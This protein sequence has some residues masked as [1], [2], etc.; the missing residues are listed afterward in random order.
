MQATFPIPPVGKKYLTFSHIFGT[1][2]SSLESFLLDRKIKGPC[3]LE[4]KNAE[5]V[6]AKVSWCKLEASCDK[7]ENVAVIRNDSDL[8]P[9]PIVIATVSIMMSYI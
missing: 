2:T 9:P 1:N 7:M 8:E 6:Q 3:W 4:V 5:S